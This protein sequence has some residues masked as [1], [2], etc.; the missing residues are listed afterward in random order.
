MVSFAAHALVKPEPGVLVNNSSLQVR[1][2]TLAEGG[3]VPDAHT[4]AARAAARPVMSVP[5]LKGQWLAAFVMHSI[6]FLLSPPN[7]QDWTL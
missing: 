4:Q 2:G 6:F 1:G 7:L 5:S 3:T